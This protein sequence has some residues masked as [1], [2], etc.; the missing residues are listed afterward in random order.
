M[1]AERLNQ[2]M[3]K[4]FHLHYYVFRIVRNKITKDKGNKNKGEENIGATVQ[5]TDIRVPGYIV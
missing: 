3:P 2:D 4:F 1:Q 5:S